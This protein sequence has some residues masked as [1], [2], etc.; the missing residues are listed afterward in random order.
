MNRDSHGGTISQSTSNAE[1]SGSSSAGPVAEEEYGDF[2]QVIQKA[3]SV[4]ITESD[5]ASIWGSIQD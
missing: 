3:K 5:Y 1:E 4:G 2:F